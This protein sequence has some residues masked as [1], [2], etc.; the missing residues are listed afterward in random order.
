M[1]T[2]K[3]EL[4]A[5]GRQARGVNLATQHLPRGSSDTTP[6]SQ[7]ILIRTFGWP[8]V[9]VARDGVESF[10]KDKCFGINE[11]DKEYCLW[12]IS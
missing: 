4:S 2:D 6:K 12:P 3:G 10:T 1:K 7:T 8:L 11:L 9:T 5:S